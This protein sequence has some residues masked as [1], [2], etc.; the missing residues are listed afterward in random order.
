MRDKYQISTGYLY[1]ILQYCNLAQ[2]EDAGNIAASM[3]RS[4]L[5]YRSRRFVRDKKLDEATYNELL[6]V[7]CNEGIRTLQSRFRIPLFNHLYQL[8]ER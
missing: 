2:Q 7:F 8:R 5:Y 4:Q 3:W 6:R 1:D